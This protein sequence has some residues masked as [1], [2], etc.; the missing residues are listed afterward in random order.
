M[1]TLVAGDGVRLEYCLDDF[2]DPWRTSETLVMLHAAMGNSRRFYAWVPHLCR[3]F[4]VVRLDLR[5]HG[6]SEVPAATSE[7]TLSR[8]V[9]DVADL[10]NHL[11]VAKVHLMGSS[12][13]GVIAQRAAISHPDRVQS[14]ALYA[15]S[16]GLK[17]NEDRLNN[18]VRRITT[19]GLRQFLEATI[20]DR[21]GPQADP[22]FV[23]WFLDETAATNLGWLARFIPL[24]GS[25]DLRDEVHRIECPTLIVA[26]GADPLDPIEQYEALKSRIRGSRMIVYDNLPHNITDAVPERCAKDLKNFL[27]SVGAGAQGHSPV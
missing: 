8:L 15:T 27:L 17:H 4:R 1:P 14:L 6:R 26:P 23:E 5:G 24:M 7:L 13:G 11:K 9:Q 21:F 10:L 16:P 18:W 20:S 22:R 25:V 3:D 2:T 19:E 12:A